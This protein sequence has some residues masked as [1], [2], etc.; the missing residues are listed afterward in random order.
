M[1]MKQNFKYG[2]VVVLAVLLHL[3]TMQVAGL[4]YTPA[5]NAG[6]DE[7][8]ISQA[9]SPCHDAYR[10]FHF[11]HTTIACE[12]GHTDLSHVP[13]DKNFLRPE[14]TF[15]KYMLRKSLISD[16]SI[17]VN[18]HSLFDPLAYYVYGLRKIVI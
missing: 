8:F 3:I 10:H 18:I 4:S 1:G 5:D 9:Y 6:K 13:T 14:V 15:R 2:I 12:M 7:C 16:I 17:H 11:Y